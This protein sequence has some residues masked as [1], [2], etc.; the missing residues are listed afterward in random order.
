MGEPTDEELLEAVPQNPAHQ[1]PPEILIGVHTAEAPD[2]LKPQSATPPPPPAAP[3]QPAAR[4]ELPG[5]AFLH[6]P[7]PAG[8]AELLPESWRAALTAEQQDWI[9][10]V[11]FTRDSS[12]RPRLITSELTLWWYPP[13]PRPIYSQPP[14]SPDPFFA[15][16]MFLYDVLTRLDEYKARITSTFGSILKMDSTKKVTKKLAGAA[17]DTAAW[18]TNVDNQYGQVLISVLTCSEG[19][20]GLSRTAAGLMR[21][22]RLTG[23]P[24]PPAHLC[25]P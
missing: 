5:P 12:G 9:G 20:E 23:L 18:L 11:L 10:R 7:P 22:Y 13:Q 21:Q 16:Q 25:G 24:A 4:E 8:S 14:V 6:R 3:R 2:A 17:S 19:S 15:C 1:Q